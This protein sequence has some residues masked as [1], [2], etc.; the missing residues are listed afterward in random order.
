MNNPTNRMK[1]PFYASLLFRVE[2][3][4]HAVDYVA[5]VT[6]IS[7]NDSQVRSAIL[8]AAKVVAGQNP[9]LPDGN[10]RDQLLASLVQVIADERIKTQMDPALAI[11][12]GK[13]ITPREWINALETVMD[14]IKT[15]TGSISG[16]RDY[17]DFLKGFMAE[18]GVEIAV[19]KE[20]E[21]SKPRGIFERIRRTFKF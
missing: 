4:I 9:K 17:L 19:M 14:S 10:A 6:G 13:E 8:R 21:G 18:S 15:R 7:L 12:V 2:T 11:G 16:S 20:T 1:D 3:H 5:K